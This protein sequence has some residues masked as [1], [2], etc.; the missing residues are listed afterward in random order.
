[1]LPPKSLL[2]TS[3]FGG[4]IQVI[5]SD[6]ILKSKIPSSFVRSTRPDDTFKRSTSLSFCCSCKFCLKRPFRD[7]FV[8][9]NFINTHRKIMNDFDLCH[10]RG[11]ASIRWRCLNRVLA[12]YFQY[13]ML[14]PHSAHDEPMTGQTVCFTLIYFSFISNHQQEYRK[15]HVFSNLRTFLIKHLIC[16]NFLRISR[17]PETPSQYPVS[18]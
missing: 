2:Y 4:N 8:A 13:F 9:V 16:Y 15:G 14:P 18:Q 12:R 1:M 11:F 7:W 17:I 3:D 6:F 10:Y 5:F